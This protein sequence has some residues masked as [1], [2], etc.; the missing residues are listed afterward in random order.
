MQQDLAPAALAAGLLVAA[1]LVVGVVLLVSRPR[2]VWP[3]AA[4]AGLPVALAVGIGAVLAS[5][6]GPDPAVARDPA[7][8]RC[9]ERS[10]ISVCVWPEHEARLGAVMDIAAKAVAGWEQH[11]IAV[12]HYFSEE[13]PDP[14]AP[15]F[16]FSAQSTE[17]DILS[18]LAYSLLPMTCPEGSTGTGSELDLLYAWFSA[19]GGM[20]DGELA[21][22]FDYPTSETGPT[23]LRL[24]RDV[25]AAPPEAQR[26]WLAK[27][28]AAA[29]SCSEPTDVPTP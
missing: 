12:P 14:L 21:R 2:W 3:H 5:P 15:S 1:G 23:V 27:T 26:A 4:V 20:A 24:V 8:L 28:L 18:A 19:T 7:A 25:S 6:L 29:S 13:A 22:R 9:A 10:G 16:G 11:G 17:T